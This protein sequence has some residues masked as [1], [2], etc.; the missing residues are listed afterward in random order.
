VS[1]TIALAHGLGVP[2]VGE[3]VETRS[4]LRTLRAS[5]CD[6]AQGF[7]LGRPMPATELQPVL[8]QPNPAVLAELDR[9]VAKAGPTR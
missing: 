7:L 9:I 2:V 6:A 4:Q 5:G 8:R 3:G 1:G